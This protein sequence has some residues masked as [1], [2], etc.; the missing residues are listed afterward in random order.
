MAAYD[1]ISDTKLEYI[2]L[3]SDFLKTEFVHDRKLFTYRPPINEALDVIF[4]SSR[5]RGI[6]EPLCFSTPGARMSTLTAQAVEFVKHHKNPTNLH[7]YFLAG[8]CDVTTKLHHPTLPPPPSFNNYKYQEVII[9]DSPNFKID[10]IK[11]TYD[12][13][14]SELTPFGCRPIFCN[15]PPCSLIDWNLSR[16]SQNKTSFLQLVDKYDDMQK[17][18]ESITSEV[19]RYISYLNSQVTGS[20]TPDLCGTI[21]KMEGNKRR[22]FYKRLAD[23]VHP[24]PELC[25]T[26]ASKIRKAIT[27]NRP[28]TEDEIAL[29]SASFDPDT[30][31]II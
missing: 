3:N 21:S 22:Y 19:N 26:W 27:K 28:E 18:L 2:L 29:M 9:R 31:E 14:I 1:N 24:T 12:Q 6:Q 25:A 5:G 23:G 8:L 13:A 11:T 30:T 7:L 20:Y 4:A 15:I 10:Q 16:L 17:N